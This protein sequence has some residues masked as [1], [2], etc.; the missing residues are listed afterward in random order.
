[1]VRVVE[2]LLET[3]DSGVFITVN[4]TYPVMEKVLKGKG[5]DVSRLFFIDCISRRAIGDSQLTERCLYVSSPSQLT[6]VS[7]GLMQA[8]EL[9]RG[10]RKFVYI[11]SLGTFLLYNSAGTMSKFSH[12]IITKLSVTEVKGIFMTAEKEKDIQLIKDLE[13]FCEKTVDLTK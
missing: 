2:A 12:F 8:L 5:V 10:K 4:R 6:E 9:L 1:M 13:V 3:H 11:D 7:V